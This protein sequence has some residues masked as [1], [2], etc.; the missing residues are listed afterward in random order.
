MKSIF[1]FGVL[2][3]LFL[4]TSCASNGVSTVSSV[5]DGKVV[6]GKSCKKK[7]KYYSKHGING[8]KG[9]VGF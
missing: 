7:K 4:M 1:T 5:K 6:K 9:M 3:S 8:Q 2:A